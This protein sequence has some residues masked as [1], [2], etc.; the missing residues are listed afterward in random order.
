MQPLDF[1]S[2]FVEQFGALAERGVEAV[3]AQLQPLD[4]DSLVDAQLLEFFTPGA[5]DDQLTP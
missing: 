3:P 1:G 5:L 2:G 4:L